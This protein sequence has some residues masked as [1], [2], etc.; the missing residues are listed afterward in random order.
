MGRAVPEEQLFDLLFDPGEARN[1]A[2]EPGYEEVVTEMR[3]RLLTWMKETADPLLSG[4]VPVPP[5]TL[6]KD[7]DALSPGG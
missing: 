2:A 6:T 7:P 4:D 3:G 1:V 5:G